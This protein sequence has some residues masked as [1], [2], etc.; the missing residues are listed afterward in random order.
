MLHGEWIGLREE[1][2]AFAHVVERKGPV[3]F[4]TRRLVVAIVEIGVQVGSETSDSRSQTCSCP[5]LI[6]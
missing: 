2:C 6:L 4:T 5:P 3:D 1:K